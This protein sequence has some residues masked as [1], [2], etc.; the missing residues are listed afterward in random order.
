MQYT[1]PHSIKSWLRQ[2]LVELPF[3]LKIDFWGQFLMEKEPGNSESLLLNVHHPGVLRKLLL[4]GDVFFLVDAYLQKLIDL[5]GDIERVL[6]IMQGLQLG[7]NWG[8]RSP[9]LWLDAW[10][11]PPLPHSPSHRSSW[12]RLPFHSRD[13]DRAAVQAHY[14]M[15]NTFYK[16]WLDPQMLYSCAYFAQ[17]QMNLQE[18][19]AAKLDRICR[20]LKLSR[21]EFLLDIGCGWGALMRWA[22]LRYGVKAHG[23][24][25]SAEQLAYNQHCIKQANLDDKITVELRDYRDL[26]SVPTFDK[27]VSVGMVEHVGAENYPAYF[28]RILGA[29]KPGGLFLNHGIASRDRWQHKSIGE[30]FI[31]RYIFPDGRL[32]PLR[33]LLGA[34]ETAGWEIVDIEAWRPH[35]AKTL[36]CWADNF[37]AAFDSIQALIGERRSRLWW[38]YLLGCALSFEQN[39]MGI[40]QT[41]L[42]PARD[43]EWNLPL[44]RDYWLC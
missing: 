12:Q 5:E 28:Q 34:A 19:Q 13:R 9:K 26:P 30:Q 44:T 18:A 14:D 11:L 23:I 39:E 22:A 36:R 32:A 31:D 21:G 6:P 25:L 4:S 35:Y 33:E 7:A 29:L 41:L 24:T 1:I 8:W 3:N 40:Y 42:R 43:R 38:L 16:L 17:P 15:G 20:K 27:I 37:M 10:T 2:C